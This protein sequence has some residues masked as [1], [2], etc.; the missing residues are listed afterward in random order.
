MKPPV[1]PFQPRHGL[2]QNARLVVLC[3][4][5]AAW[6]CAVLFRLYW[7]QVERYDHYQTKAVEQQ[8]RVV[9]LDP[10]RGTIYDARGRQLAVSV[11]VSSIA[12]HPPSV[13][14]PEATADQLSQILGTDRDELLKKLTSSRNFV[15]VQTQG[16]PTEGGRHP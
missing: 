16:G 9:V 2:W 14:D 12:A 4:A 6:A 11:E 1:V 10:P 3:A 8:Q 5:A 7:L 13:E 15:W